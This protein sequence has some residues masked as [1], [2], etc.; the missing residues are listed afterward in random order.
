MSDL[1]PQHSVLVERSVIASILYEPNLADDAI[2]L[3]QLSHFYE[4]RNML[5]FSAMH[6]LYS[7]GKPIDIPMLCDQL[8]KMG[9][10]EQVGETY[11]SE[12]STTSA[13]S[14]N[15]THYF[16]VLEEKRL[17]R[18]LHSA[19]LE[20]HE[21]S[22]KAESNPKELA[23]AFENR[24]LS[25]QSSK[26]LK[27]VRSVGEL[28]S[29]FFKGLE[30]RAKTGGI[31]G[32]KSGFSELDTMTR[33]FQAGDFIIIG[34]RPGMGKTALALSLALNSAKDGKRTL[35]F[36][37]EMLAEQIENRF[38]SIQS[39]VDADTIKSGHATQ[40]IF[41]KFSNSASVLH[42]LPIYIDDDG[43]RNII[44]IRATA[45]KIIREYGDLGLIVIDYIQLMS[46][47]GKSESRQVEISN[48]SR[49]LKELAK[50]LKIPIIALAQLSRNVEQRTGAEHR[51]QLSDLRESGSLEQDADIVLF[52]YRKAY[53]LEIA[54]K[55]D[56]DEYQQCKNHAELIVAK[57][58]NGSTGTVNLIWEGQFG[59]FSNAEE[60][61]EEEPRF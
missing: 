11:I 21:E 37:L 54:K 51:P 58:R 30:D 1:T 7:Q 34:A 36:T 55:K 53:Y 14:S 35:I 28:L 61:R 22:A 5:I 15:L 59:R 50:E 56:T 8:T 23:D 42:S 10:M 45:R 9:T 19:S 52:L 33:G 13:T 49:G 31:S 24:I 46:G 27:K 3:F 43:N 39:G 29:G 57:Q 17:L 2:Q 20:L 38:M 60:R 47:I 26:G 40:E 44:D 25:A 16:S 41:E 6:A 12:V 18:V 32:V 4:N 48:I